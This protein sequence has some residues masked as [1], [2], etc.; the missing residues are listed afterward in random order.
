MDTAYAVDNLYNREMF[1]AKL[2]IPA[3]D[4]EWQEHFDALKEQCTNN[5]E[6]CNRLAVTKDLGAGEYDD[7]GEVMSLLKKHNKDAEKPLYCVEID[8]WT[9]YEPL[10]REVVA[11]RKAMTKQEREEFMPEVVMRTLAKNQWWADHTT[12]K[13]HALDYEGKELISINGRERQAWKQHGKRNSVGG[14]ATEAKPKKKTRKGT[15]IRSCCEGKRC[16]CK[17]SKGGR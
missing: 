13:D 9:R 15:K 2:K 7:K 1:A 12:G 17:G 16:R 4:V 6:N 8:P 5:F 10:E 14:A 11:A 3:E